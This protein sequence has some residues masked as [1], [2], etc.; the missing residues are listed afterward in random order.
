MQKSYVNVS[1]SH[2]L[3]KA[4]I[5]EFLIPGKNNLPKGLRNDLKL[6]KLRHHAI[7]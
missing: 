6:S 1:H 2:S 5:E 3:I 4:K 7:T